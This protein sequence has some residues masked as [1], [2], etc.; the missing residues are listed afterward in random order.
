MSAA[1]LFAAV[2]LPAGVREELA[3]WA[4]TVVGE[5]TELRL[6]AA[7]SLH[8]TLA[9]L[10]WRD[11]AEMERIGRLV[12]ACADAAVPLALEA[13]LWLAPR[14]PHVLT[15]ALRDVTGALGEL[16]RNVVAAL[17][18]GAGFE[19]ERRAFSPHVTVARVRRG[20]RVRPGSV[21]LPPLAPRKFAAAALSLY[22]SRLSP[23][24]SRYEPVARV[25]LAGP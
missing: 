22:R 23:A 1:R 12:V 19:P 9:F 2:D 18:A 20:G 14:R 21:E 4:R 17:V 11:E 25:E 3:A 10:G 15:V 24:G 5:R 8:V 6:L 7:E 13:P 16:Q